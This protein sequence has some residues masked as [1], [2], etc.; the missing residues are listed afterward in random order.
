M[1]ADA[2]IDGFLRATLDLS[3]GKARALVETG[4][5]FIDGTRVLDSAAHVRAGAKVVVD[6]SAPKPRSHVPDDL[7]V[8]MDTHVI[9]VR[10]PA[11]ISTVPFDD[12]EHGTLDEL[13]RRVLPK[14]SNNGPRP[15]LGVVHRLDKETTGLVVFTRTWLAKESLA[16][17]FRAHT[18]RRRYLAI[19]HGDVGRRRIESRLVAD[20]GDGL[21]GST[22][23]PNQ[24]QL[25]V[26]H[27]EPLEK[28]EGATL[29]ACTLETG[30]THQIRIHLAELGHPIVGER[31]YIRDFR[32][33]PLA[34]S[35]VMLHA[36]ELGFVHP[37]AEREVHWEEPAPED[38]RKTLARLRIKE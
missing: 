16:S 1:K 15:S 17:Q 28:L 14:S 29:I 4:K 2:Q 33:P 25:A 11:G 31:V 38:F 34:A 30:R 24:G 19:A 6:A 18:V 23:L 7:I 3:W 8:F 37:K 20:R 13:V 26:T 12:D 36:T 22:K 27:V 21:R 35:R 9:I 5:V 10:K 32:G